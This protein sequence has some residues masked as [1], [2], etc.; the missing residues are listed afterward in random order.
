MIWSVAVPNMT[1]TTEHIL[2]TPLAAALAFNACKIA[3]IWKCLFVSL[4]NCVL[5]CLA[6]KWE[7]KFCFRFCSTLFKLK[8]SIHN[9]G[10]EVKV[11]RFEYEPWSNM[12]MW[13]QLLITE[14]N[15]KNAWTDLFDDVHND[16]TWLAVL[17]DGWPII[18]TLEFRTTP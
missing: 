11:L 6:R 2:V 12:S 5:R 4:C 18:S 10:N 15:R 8:V 13:S 1:V 16:N 17:F 14:W 7:M 3:D 9:Y